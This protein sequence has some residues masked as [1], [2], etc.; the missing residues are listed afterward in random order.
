MK[1]KKKDT[2]QKVSNSADVWLKKGQKGRKMGA[3]EEGRG[4][5]GMAVK[6]SGG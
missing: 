5:G 4:G 6:S 1:K 2:L 3:L